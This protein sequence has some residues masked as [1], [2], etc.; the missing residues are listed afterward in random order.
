M[1]SVL[2]LV[3]EGLVLVLVLIL[4]LESLVLVLV[5]GGSA[6]VN[7][8][9]QQ[10]IKCIPTAFPCSHSPGTRRNQC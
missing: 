10:D 4:V 5:L 2:V 1:R 9:G 3:L 6:L 8:T 7:I